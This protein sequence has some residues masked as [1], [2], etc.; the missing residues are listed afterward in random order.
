M[1]EIVQFQVKATDKF[2]F[3][4]VSGSRKKNRKQEQETMGQLNMFQVG[5]GKSVRLKPHGS[6]FEEALALDEL[7]DPQAADRY[8]DAIQEGE[9]IA[10][11]Y[12]NLGIL[13]SKLGNT[14]KSIECFTSSLKS[15]ASHFETHFNLANLYFDESDY[16]PARVHYELARQIDPSYSN[17]YFNL[18]LVQS[19]DQDF[20]A[21]IKSLEKYLEVSDEE[22]LKAQEILEILKT[23]QAEISSE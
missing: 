9:N 11:A 20:E 6:I 12:C 4:R 21:G 3:K 10:D 22:N 18:G 7:E 8:R 15:D 23:S 19:L 1:G 16:A 13:E 17:L 2:G 5:P 14:R